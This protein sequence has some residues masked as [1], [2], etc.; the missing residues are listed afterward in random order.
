MKKKRTSAL[1]YL[2]VLAVNFYLLPFLAKDTGAAMVLMLCV[3][4]LVTFVASIAY[5]AR[6]GFLLLLPAAAAVL[7]IPTIWIHYNGTA[8]VYSV[9]YGLIALAGTGMGTLFYRKK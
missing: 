5:G 2:A 6:S 1:P 9:I 8:W 3:M 4:P 7:F